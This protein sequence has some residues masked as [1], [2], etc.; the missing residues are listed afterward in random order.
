MNV[1]ALGNLKDILVKKPG[2]S[3]LLEVNT[4]QT[5]AGF[6]IITDSVKVLKAK[7][8][9]SYIFRVKLSSPRANAFQNLTIDESAEGTRVFVNTYT[10]SKKWVANWRAGKAE[11][12]EGDIDVVYLNTGLPLKSSTTNKTSATN[13]TIKY[14]MPA[15]DCTTTTYYEY[16]PYSC[17]SGNHGPDDAGCY[18]TGNDAAGYYVFDYTVTNCNG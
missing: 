14:A 8:H 10:P 12:F 16:L 15:E 5:Y 11:K 13:I 1:L 4:Q 7:G 3:K 18:L 17:A 2:N 6:T 9:T